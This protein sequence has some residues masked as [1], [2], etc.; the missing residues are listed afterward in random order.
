[1]IRLL[2]PIPEPHINIQLVGGRGSDGCKGRLIGIDVNVG[3][4]AYIFISALV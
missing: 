1:V 2:L 3:F 4:T